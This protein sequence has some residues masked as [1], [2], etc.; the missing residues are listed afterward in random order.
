M[1]IV[2]NSILMNAISS[3]LM[4]KPFISL[5]INILILNILIL[6]YISYSHIILFKYR[7]IFKITY[8]LKFCDFKRIISAIKWRFSYWQNFSSRSPM[9]T[10]RRL[11]KRFKCII[12]MLNQSHKVFAIAK[13]KAVHFQKSI[14]N[15]FFCH[16]TF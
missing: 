5:V 11:T 1:S 15:R 6:K 12:F 3:E 2:G 9:N 7:F 13:Q 14:W 8:M 16:I 10:R 4:V